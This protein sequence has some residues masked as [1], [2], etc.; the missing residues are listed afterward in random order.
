MHHT[1]VGG[2]RCFVAQGARFS[3]GAIFRRDG[4]EIRCDWLSD[5]PRDLHMHAIIIE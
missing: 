5:D 2:E 3:V 1:F 4:V